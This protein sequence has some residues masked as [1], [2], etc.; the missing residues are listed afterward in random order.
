[1][2][3]LMLTGPLLSFNKIEECVC[4]RGEG[5]QGVQMK[6]KLLI[7]MAHYCRMAGNIIMVVKQLT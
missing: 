7:F 3:L 6:L 1:M 4:V 5:G 2:A